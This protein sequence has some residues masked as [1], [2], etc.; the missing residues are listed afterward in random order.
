MKKNIP[1]SLK[2]NA[3]IRLF[4]EINCVWTSRKIIQRLV[5]ELKIINFYINRLSKITFMIFALIAFN[6]L[7]L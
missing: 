4:L 2:N 6:Q 3:K 1:Y 5:W 7:I